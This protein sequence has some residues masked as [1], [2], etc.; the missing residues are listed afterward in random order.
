MPQRSDIPHLLALLD[1][2]TPW[3]RKQITEELRG[4]GASLEEEISLYHS[5]LNPSQRWFLAKI[6]TNIRREILQYAWPNWLD[7][8][9]DLVALEL[10]FSQLDYL[11]EEENAHL[12]TQ[13]LDE[14][15]IAF[16]VRTVSNTPSNL[17]NFMFK[18]QNLSL[19]LEDPHHPRFHSLSHILK[20]RQ[21]SQIGLSVLALLLAKRLEIEL[22]GLNVPGHFVLVSFEGSK[23][24]LYNTYNR[25]EAIAQTSV[26]YIERNFQKNNASIK[27]M[28]ARPY[29]IVL[30][31]LCDINVTYL[32]REM[33]NKASIYNSLYEQ[34]MNHL[35][36]RDIVR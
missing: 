36:K 28:V 35:R 8:P 13:K 18:Q 17:M 4:F 27:D 15:A 30:Q 25:G 2:D 5:S 24:K 20:H 33:E 31:V 16:Q 29:E 19:P 21:G 23:A 9:D 7:E 34:L 26:L 12:L 6:I 14:L 11:T 22:Y 3:I 1:D 10:A 32:K